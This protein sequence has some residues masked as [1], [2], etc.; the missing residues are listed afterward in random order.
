MTT[1]E[2]IPTLEHC[3]ETAAK[4]EFNRLTGLYLDLGK[5]D[6]DIETKLELLRDF[7]E[8]ADFRSLRQD[9]SFYLL[10]GETVKF[11]ITDKDDTLTF[12]MEV[13]PAS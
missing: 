8:T 13:I 3:I 5:E 12:R 2:L 11:I 4:M 7:L 6:A 10:V 9:S 1:I